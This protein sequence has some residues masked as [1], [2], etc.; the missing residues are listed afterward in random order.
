MSWRPRVV[1]ILLMNSPKTLR[2]CGDLKTTLKAEVCGVGWTVGGNFFAN[3]PKL[4]GRRRTVAKPPKRRVR[5]RAT[6]SGTTLSWQCSHS[7]TN[8]ISE[9]LLF[10]VC[11]CV[12]RYIFISVLFS[13][14][15]RGVCV[16][17]GYEDRIHLG[18]ILEEL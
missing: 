3:C 5:R 8:A 13:L 7:T 1:E 16:R 9:L 14:G 18:R 10:C 15:V 17:C 12:M 6:P 11:V 4:R 2:V